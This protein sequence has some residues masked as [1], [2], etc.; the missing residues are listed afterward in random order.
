MN[1]FINDEAKCDKNINLLNILNEIIKTNKLYVLRG[2]L[3]IALFYNKIYRCH[4]D[5][6]LYLDYNDFYF[7]NN[8]FCEKYEFQKSKIPKHCPEKMY[9]FSSGANH[10]GHIVFIKD[11]I[12]KENI[13]N[14][15]YQQKR[16][17]DPDLLNKYSKYVPMTKEAVN[18]ALHN[19]EEPV[20][21]INFGEKNINV[22][23]IRYLKE[24]KIFS[25]ILKHKKD[26]DDDL[27][28]YFNLLI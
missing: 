5:I 26:Q 2:G 3:A 4:K 13:I 18:M 21:K 15:V 27:S 25:N 1:L 10:L 17:N 12:K 16:Y 22:L 7:W 11:L 20:I 6:D 19:F 23:N 8:F 28:F 24:Q 14:Q 9:N